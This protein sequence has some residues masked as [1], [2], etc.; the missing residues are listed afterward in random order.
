MGGWETERPRIREAWP[1][2][3]GSHRQNRGS[4]PGP[5][6]V[7]L[8]LTELSA[9]GQRGRERGGSFGLGP[10]GDGGAG[11][12]TERAWQRHTFHLVMHPDHPRG[13][14]HAEGQTVPTR[15]GVPQL[16]TGSWASGGTGRRGE[17]GDL[18]V[19]FFLLRPLPVDET[20]T[21]PSSHLS[22]WCQE[23]TPF[24]VCC[25]WQCRPDLLF[26]SFILQFHSYLLNN[27]VVVRD[28]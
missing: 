1:R 13:R 3:H 15:P 22:Y 6:C 19:C 25:F 24:K 26:L 16:G 8:H 2:S 27:G 9:V 17:G 23:P 18:Q 11:R 20:P 21:L 28:M 14:S 7:L 12:A 4:N 5:R 10:L